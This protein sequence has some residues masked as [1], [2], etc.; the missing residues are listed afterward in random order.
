MRRAKSILILF[1]VMALIITSYQ[2]G[3]NDA[4]SGGSYSRPE[5][6]K[7]SQTDDSGSDIDNTEDNDLLSDNS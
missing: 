7:P 5:P 6:S 4:L 3:I 2:S 1:T